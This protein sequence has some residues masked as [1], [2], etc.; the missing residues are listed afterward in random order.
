MQQAWLLH[1]PHDCPEMVVTWPTS[2][3]GCGG[4]RCCCG[5]EPLRLPSFARVGGPNP[6][7]DSELCLRPPRRPPRR[8]QIWGPT[9]QC[10]RAW[11]P[12]ETLELR[13]AA[14]ESLL[15]LVL[16]L[17]PASRAEEVLAPRRSE[18]ALLQRVPRGCARS[19]CP[20]S[21]DARVHHISRGLRRSAKVNHMLCVCRACNRCA[22]VAVI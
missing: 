4:S 15:H 20:E 19:S 9:S 10:A 17:T 11:A 12:K 6:P 22:F 13:Q 2:V 5:F 8:P 1:Q 3:A 18:H 16:G 14:R 21:W 7:P